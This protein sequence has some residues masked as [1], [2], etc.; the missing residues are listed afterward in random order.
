MAALLKEHEA[1]CGAERT[2]LLVDT[3]GSNPTALAWA[4]RCDIENRRRH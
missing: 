1:T 3:L 2:D 4:M